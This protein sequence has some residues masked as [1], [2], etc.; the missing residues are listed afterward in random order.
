MFSTHDEI[1]KI[2]L[3]KCKKDFFIVPPKIWKLKKQ[4]AM[5]KKEFNTVNWCSWPSAYEFFCMCMCVNIFVFVSTCKCL[6]V[7]SFRKLDYS[8]NL[9]RV[10]VP[11]ITKNVFL[12]T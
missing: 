10:Y 6:H 5:E 9:S 7:Y 8:K 12:G 11:K 4:K 2:G 1:E 3:I